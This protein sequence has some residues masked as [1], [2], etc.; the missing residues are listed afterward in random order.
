MHALHLSIGAIL[1]L[2]MTGML[3][4]SL[5]LMRTLFASQYRV[6]TQPHWQNTAVVAVNY[7]ETEGVVRKSL[8]SVLSGTKTPSLFVVVFN[9]PEIGYERSLAKEYSDKIVFIFLEK[10][11]KRRAMRRGATYVIQDN[12]FRKETEQ[13]HYIV[14]MDGDTIWRKDTLEELVKPF[15]DERI[16]AVAAAQHYLNEDETTWTMTQAL[17]SHWGHTVGQKWQSAVFSASCLRGRTNAFRIEV[18]M[19]NGFLEEF[20]EW[21]FVGNRRKSGDDGTLTFLVIKYNWINKRKRG[22]TF[23]QM[24]SVIDTLAEPGWDKFCKM[25]VRCMTNTHTRYFDAIIRSWFWAQS[26]RFKLE[27]VT[28]VLIPMG[29]FTCTLTFVTACIIAMDPYK[30]ETLHSRLAP[31]FLF[32]WYMA[33]RFLRAPIWAF[34]G[35]RLLRWP[36]MVFAMLF[37]LVG[38]RWWAMIIIFVP[39]KDWGSRNDKTIAI[40]FQESGD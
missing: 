20:S 40:G 5:F 32:V 14:H 36:K 3:F 34:K 29:F 24:S 4:W 15:V 37:P 28:S 35:I 18:L 10:G 26:W 39:Q 2:G 23:V 7:R 16:D 22:G 25:R 12:L 21:Y 8:N 31:V 1:S 13:I 19:Q 9:G 30:I 33:G 38:L 27:F 11:D 17:L 6:Y